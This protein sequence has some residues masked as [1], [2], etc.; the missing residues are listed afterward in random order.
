MSAPA[1]ARRPAVPA[2]R[3]IEMAEDEESEAETQGA[4]WMRF[5]TEL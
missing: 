3:M 1:D 2:R 4:I 5:F